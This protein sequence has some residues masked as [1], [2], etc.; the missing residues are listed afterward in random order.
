MTLWRSTYIPTGEFEE[1][2]TDDPKLCLNKLVLRLVGDNMGAT[3]PLISFKTE[4]VE[5][6]LD[7]DELKILQLFRARNYKRII[8]LLQDDYAPRA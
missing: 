2:E 5:K 3:F 6:P 8:E 7:L 4:R 1:L